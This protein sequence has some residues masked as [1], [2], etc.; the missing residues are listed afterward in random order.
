MAGENTFSTLNGWF[1]ELYASSE[2]RPLPKAAYLLK[3][4]D[5]SKAERGVGNKYHMPVVLTHEHGVTYAGP[6]SGAFTLNAP[7][8]S[9]LKDAT[10]EGTQVLLRSR[11]DYESAAR[12]ANT[13]ASFG[14]ATE[15]LVKNMLDSIS[16]RLEIMMLY[17]RQSIGA[18]N[19]STVGSTSFVISAVTW[20]GAIWAGMENAKLDITASDKSAYSSAGSAS[21][22]TISSVNLGTRTITVSGPLTLTGG[23]LVWFAGAVIPGGSP[24]FNEFYGLDGIIQE[25]STLFGI[26]NSTFN[27]FQGNVSDLASTSMTVTNILSGLL[28]SIGKGL[29]QDVVLLCSPKGFQN[30]VNPLVDPKASVGSTNVQVGSTRLDRKGGPSLEL[31]SSSAKIMGNQGTI[32]IIPHL[33]VKDGDAFAVPMEHLKRVGATDV[34]FNTPGRGDEFFLQLPDNAGF[35]LRVYANQALFVETPGWCTKYKN[36]A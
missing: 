3:N 11:L 16:K 31:G 19:A 22:V 9:V 33:F 13:K 29:M 25:A 36:L 7:V 27:M 32:E 35:E 21:N 12:A 20:A 18:V 14:Q 6:S 1:K 34:T 15:L 28:P 23:D 10:I 24:T 2:S 30:L 5:F 26:T 17:G 4:I 8:A